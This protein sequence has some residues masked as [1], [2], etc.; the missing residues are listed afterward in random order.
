MIISLNEAARKVI[1]NKIGEIREKISHIMITLKFTLIL[2]LSGLFSIG[3]TT[4]KHRINAL[5]K[6]LN[7][8][9]IELTF[10]MNDSDYQKAILL[11]DQ[12]T[13]VDSNY[14]LAYWNKLVFQLQLKQYDKAIVT[15]KNLIRIRT[16]A[17]DLHLT[18]GVLY[19]RVRDSLSAEKEFQEALSLYDKFLD[20]MSLK[21]K[22]YDMLSVN[23]AV[24]LIMLGEQ[25]K[26]NEFLKQL[27]DR[28]ADDSLKGLILSFMN[29]NKK[30]LIETIEHRQSA[31]NNAGLT[32]VREQAREKYI[33]I[34]FTN[35]AQDECGYKNIKGD[36][37]IPFGKY[38]VCFTDTFRTYA[39]VN[40]AHNAFVAIDRQ[41]NILY[42]V[43]PFDNG[44]DYTSEGLFRI[45]VKNRIGYADSSTGKIVINP[46][47]GCAWPFE[48][49]IA[50]V[51]IDC[52]K[53]SDGEH[54]T[55]LS[56]N[57]FYINKAGKK[58]NPQKTKKRK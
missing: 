3:Q 29:K 48:H 40:T 10:T 12:A 49:G 8:S 54:S 21:N 16:T 30:D 13:A 34:S 47:F 6:K 52:H 24:D 4:S 38:S 14:F 41:E 15:S 22:D 43:F 45:L 56:D 55:W 1:Q 42:E 11:L 27:Y 28:Q 5:A 35:S 39:I 31:T 7:D 23:K 18:F 25:M 33:L 9:A 19:E 44:P 58:V 53:S 36:T 2:L 26:G 17:P 37:I 46:Q 32:S 57:W 51:S 50:K 20:T